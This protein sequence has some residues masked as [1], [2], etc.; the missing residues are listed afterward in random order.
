MNIYK[1]IFKDTETSRAIKKLYFSN[2]TD[3]DDFILSHVGLVFGFKKSKHEVG[4]NKTDIIHFLNDENS[5]E[6]IK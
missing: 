1:V 4:R 6:E 3:Q 2:K 5:N